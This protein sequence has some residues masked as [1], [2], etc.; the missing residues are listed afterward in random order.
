MARVLF[1]PPATPAPDRNGLAM[2]AGVTVDGVAQRHELDVAVVRFPGVGASLD[3]V[4]SRCHEVIDVALDSDRVPMR[5]WVD[6]E[7]GRRV[8]AAPLPELARYRPPS[9]GAR[10]IEQLGSAFDVVIVMGTYNAGLAIPFL[11]AGVPALLDAFDDDAS[12]C[13]SLATID[14]TQRDQVPLYET[15]QREVFPWFERV[16]FASMDDAG[17]PER[18]LPNAVRIPESWGTRPRADPLELLYIGDPGYVPNADALDRLRR[19]IV[20]AIEAVVP[21]VRLLHPDRAK[22]VDPYYD[23]AHLAVVPL[24]AG[25]GT[26]IKILEA[27]AR[28]CPVVATPTAAAGLDVAHDVHLVV[29]DDDDDDSGFARAVIELAADEPR[30][31]R[32]ATSA[33]AFV[34]EHHDARSVGERLATLVDEVVDAHPI[35]GG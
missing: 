19:S 32:L 12:T 23:Q 16:L 28:G 13:A 27:F 14:A 8:V 11:E 5:S 2:R 31:H 1:V 3:W 34:C 4:R 17:T 24:R 7:R 33:R 18:Y 15:F 9:F 22:S 20:P 26:R 25:G 6:T 35:R 10:I 30:R 29:T 21:S